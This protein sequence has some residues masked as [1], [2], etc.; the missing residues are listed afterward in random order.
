VAIWKECG[1]LIQ[2]IYQSKLQK[3]QKDLNVKQSQRPL[4]EWQR[5]RMTTVANRHMK[6]CSTLLIIRE[7]PRKTTMKTPSSICYL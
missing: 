4:E 6:G 2:R 7:M 1:S 5:K 3:E